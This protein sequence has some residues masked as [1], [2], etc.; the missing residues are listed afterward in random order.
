MTRIDMKMTPPPGLSPKELH[1]WGR[2]GDKGEHVSPSDTL[3][4]MDL[5]KWKY[6]KYI[7]DYLACVRSVDDNIGRLLTYL[8]KSGLSENTIVVY[9]SDQ[10]FN[11]GDMV[12]MTNVLCTR[13]R[14]ACPL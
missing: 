1:T 7:K 11:L 10:G 9:T 5:K 6:Q 2:T 8:D 4:G 14:F 12:G 3:T 13:S